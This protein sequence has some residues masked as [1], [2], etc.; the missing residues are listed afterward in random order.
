MAIEYHSYQKTISE[1]HALYSKRQLNLAPGFQRDSIWTKSERTSLI[2]F[3]DPQLSAPIDLP[4][5][6]PEGG[7]VVY[8]VIDGKQRIE[9]IFGFIGTIRLKQLGRSWAAK[10]KLP[11]SETSELVN[12]TR[13]NKMRQQYRIMDYRV[14][15]IEV[16]GT[17]DEIRDLFVRINSTGKPLKRQ[18]VRNAKFLKTEFLGSAKQVANR[19]RSYFQAAGVVSEQQSERMKHIELASELIYSAHAGDVANKKRVLDDVMDADALK[20]QTLRKAVLRSVSALNRLRRMFPGIN[21]SVRFHKISDFC[22]LAVLI[23][24][25]EAEGL[26]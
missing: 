23:Q 9:L 6:A 10:V 18:E 20:G 22:T 1:L 13:L 25:F 2:R 15:T 5:Q 7:N 19:F 11:E 21:R 8:D 16:D 26:V 14:Q 3:N 12:W 24:K 17:W 4:V